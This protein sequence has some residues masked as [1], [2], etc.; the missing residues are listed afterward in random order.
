MATLLDNV[1]TEHFHPYRKF[2]WTAL[3]THSRP[4]EYVPTFP[5]PISIAHTPWPRIWVPL[6]SFPDS[7]PFQLPTYNIQLLPHSRLHL[8]TLTFTFIH[9]FKIYWVPNECVALVCTVLEMEKPGS[10]NSLSPKGIT[11][12][13]GILIITLSCWTRIHKSNHIISL[14][15]HLH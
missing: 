4:Q 2:Y 14:L 13:Q 6:A 15:T 7:S 8:Q 3:S 11:I 9:S 5:Q 12:K 10:F 1:N